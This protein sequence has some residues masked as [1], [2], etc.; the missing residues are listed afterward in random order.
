MV[1]K[2][3]SIYAKLI[4]FMESRQS[5]VAEYIVLSTFI[6]PKGINL[7]EMKWYIKYDILHIETKDGMIEVRPVTAGSESDFKHPDDTTI[8]EEEV[9]EDYKDEDYTSK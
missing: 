9:E 3:E 4:D 8:Q 2:N 6:I 1:V 5:I 7:H